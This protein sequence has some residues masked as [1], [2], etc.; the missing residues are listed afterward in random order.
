MEVKGQSAREGIPVGNTVGSVRT[1]PDGASSAMLTGFLLV[2]MTQTFVS[3][4]LRLTGV[5]DVR[6]PVE[7]IVCSV[8]N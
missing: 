5:L 4:A 7:R 3:A 1:R 2:R 8:Q 6:T